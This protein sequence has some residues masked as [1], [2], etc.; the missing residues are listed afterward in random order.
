MFELMGIVIGDRLGLYAALSKTP[1]QTSTEL[2]KAVSS[3]ERYIREW[4]EHQTVSGILTVEDE[5]A[6]AKERRFSLPKGHAEAL[7][8]AES[9][10]YLTPFLRLAL[11]TAPVMPKLIDAYKTGKGVPWSAYGAEAREGQGGANRATFLQL[12]GKD[13]LPKIKEVDERLKADP[14]ARVADFGTGLGW[15]AIAMAQAYPKIKVDGYDIDAASVESATAN[16]KAAGVGDRVTFHAKSA[17]DPNLKGDYDLATGFEMLHD[18]S[19]PVAALKTMKRLVGDKGSVLIVDERVGDEFSTKADE[20]ERLMYGWSITMCLPNGKDDK[21]S[22]ETGT[23]MRPNTLKAYATEAGFTK[24]EILPIENYF[25]RL[26][27][28]KG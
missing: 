12:L 7:I 23:V 8:D 16:A 17:Y 11:S 5:K 27:H 24:F 3:D 9:L 13:W 4:L 20:V 14:P 21:V 22:A 10:N 19:Q 2:A 1:K 15:S 25:F 18:L 6:S 28:I 26:Y